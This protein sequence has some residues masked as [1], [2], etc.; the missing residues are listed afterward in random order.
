MMVCRRSSDCFNSGTYSAS[1]PLRSVIARHP[2]ITQIALCERLAAATILIL[3]N[4]L[5][6][7]NTPGSMTPTY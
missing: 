2:Q 4:P 7:C 5:Q 3:P 6:Q 1:W